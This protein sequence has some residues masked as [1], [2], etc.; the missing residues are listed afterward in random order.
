MKT[1]KSQVV[2][3]TNLNAEIEQPM[4]NKDLVANQEYLQLEDIENIEVLSQY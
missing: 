1:V 3:N 4:E 2:L